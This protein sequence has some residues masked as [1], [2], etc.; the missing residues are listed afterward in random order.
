MII[1]GAFHM[2]VVIITKWQN[3]VLSTATA[4]E[5]GSEI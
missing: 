3:S 5:F 1:L 2:N 4:G